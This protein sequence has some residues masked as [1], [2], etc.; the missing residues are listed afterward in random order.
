M[1]DGNFIL[2]SSVESL[3]VVVKF[4]KLTSKSEVELGTKWL[5]GLIPTEY[6]FGFIKSA[7]SM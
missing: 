7:P 2:I 3:G 6:N 5:V 4:V 1:P